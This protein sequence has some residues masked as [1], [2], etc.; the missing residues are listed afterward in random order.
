MRAQP[1]LLFCLAM[2]SFSV[3]SVAR[4]E[5]GLASYY[6]YGKAGKGGELT[7]AHRTRPFG[8]VLR[9]SYGSRSI[10]CRV[11][12]RGP[13]IRGRIVDLSVPAARAL[14]MMSAGVVRVSVE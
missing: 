4:A 5:S 2:F 7:C 1:T 11:N 3:V 14:G 6:G 10:Q 12:D 9:V 13:F 8:S